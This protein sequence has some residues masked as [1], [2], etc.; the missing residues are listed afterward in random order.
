MIPNLEL[1]K[2][3]KETKEKIESQDKSWMEDSKKIMELIFAYLYTKGS[4]VEEKFLTNFLTH[5]NRKYD[6]EFPAMAGVHFDKGS[7]YLTINPLMM[8]VSADLDSMIKIITHE[9]YHIVFMHSQQ[10]HLASD[11]EVANYAMDISVNQYIDFKPELYKNLITIDW[12]KKHIDPNGLEKQDWLY[13]Y[14][15]ILNSN[16]LKE[17]K[18]LQKEMEDKLKDLLKKIKESMES[19]GNGDSEN[20]EL[21][22]LLKEL[23]DILG[24][25]SASLH[26]QSVTEKLSDVEKQTLSDITKEILN[27]SKQRG[28]TPGNIA[29]KIEEL[30]FKKPILDWKKELRN[31]VGSVPFPY[32]KTM[33]VRNRRCP[34]RTDI[35]G[36]VND[37]CVNIMVAVDTSGSVSDDELKY[38]F[39]EVFNI[40]KDFNFSLRI[41]ECDSS[42]NNVY[43]IKS[44]NDF[45]ME[46]N[47]RGG[48]CFQPVFEY[49]YND[50][51]VKEETDIILFFTDGFGEGSIE[52]TY[53]PKVPVLWV[54]TSDKE[55]N[56][57][58]Q[59]PEMRQRIRLL[60]IE[61]KKFM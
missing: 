30:F 6:N 41:V 32:R 13:Y 49:V 43:T 38:F 50:R 1:E 10:M 57:S 3:V 22:E 47:G 31:I 24:N 54:L 52:Q 60:N 16:F 37:R 48:T 12:F 36:H 2:F 15:A 35:L 17:Q 61:D 9:I 11:K 4:S 33:R 59:N 42:I 39:N 29:E 23:K 26:G 55:E 27:S 56:L 25:S 8:I 18:K 45:H 51:K 5:M 34:E 28:M 58:V 20:E 46:I 7:F 44:K 53:I 19:G 40:I 14:Q 21:K